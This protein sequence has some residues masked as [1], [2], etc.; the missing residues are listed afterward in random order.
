MPA[1]ATLSRPMRRSGQDPV[2]SSVL[3]RRMGLHGKI[4]AVVTAPMLL[5]ALLAAFIVVQAGRDSSDAR[6][7]ATVNAGLP[8]L[9]RFVAQLQSE[10]TATL[11]YLREQ[12]PQNEGT[13]RKQ[14]Q[15][16]DTSVSRLSQEIDLGPLA[17]RAPA[18]AVDARSL[19]ESGPGTLLV[20]R[21][22][23]D[24][25][26]SSAGPVGA[27][28]DTVMGQAINIPRLVADN[29]ADRDAARSMRGFAS[30]LSLS[31]LAARER[32]L[33][34]GAFDR[35]SLTAPEISTYSKTVTEQNTAAADLLAVTGGDF[36]EL[37]ER[38]AEAVSTVDL[39]PYRI[40][41][42]VALAG[43]GDLS[44]DP[45]AW[46]NDS[47]ERIDAILRL[48]D[49]VSSQVVTLTE[50]RAGNA[51]RVLLSTLTGTVLAALIAVSLT[52]AMSRRITLP[53]RSLTRSA[54]DLS[55]KLPQMVEQMR[56]PGER[57]MIDLE[58]IR[59][60]SR[61]EVGELAS[62]F[63]SVNAVTV[64]VA[65][66]QAALRGSIAAMYTQMARRN[67]VLL[68]R[69]LAYLDELEMKELNSETLSS[70]FRLDHLATRMRRNS[71]SLLVLAGVD[72]SRTFSKPLPLSEVIRGAMGE[73]EDYHRIDLIAGVNA[74][75]SGH[76]AM[77][78]SHLIAELLENATQF[79][80]PQTRV[81]VTLSATETGAAVLIRDQG[82]GMTDRDLT[83]ANERIAAPPVVE[84]AGA[85]QLGF[86]VV[87]RL[88]QRLGAGVALRH[89][90]RGGIVAEVTLPVA[91]LDGAQNKVIDLSNLGQERPT[92]PAVLA[93]PSAPVALPQRRIRGTSRGQRPTSSGR[94]LF[95]TPTAV[96]TT[97]ELG[98]PKPDSAGA[99]VEQPNARQH[100]NGIGQWLRAVTVESGPGRR[101]QHNDDEEHAGGA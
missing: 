53:L 41:V 62:A 26:T 1:E 23:T 42:E 64:R 52:L 92:V 96:T 82:L 4:L 44:R 46:L 48:L 39:T 99:A 68:D 33:L 59:I 78:L 60:E 47:G 9:G 81:Q 98:A 17:D 85:Q 31:E 45:K 87:G 70:L 36:P 55:V 77:S 91:A 50:A 13:V 61:D 56:R 95:E 25:G 75:V 74:Q 15:L 66:E 93:A 11:S 73:I 86:F 22:Q 24:S 5:V 76:L 97:P 100:G 16:T 38:M 71:E 84:V 32:D 3:P 27:L 49:P 72:A 40:N 54:K 51:E 58:P 30:L 89:G 6:D 34:A 43:R 29:L 57:P 79:S 10:R 28:Y 65:E 69:Q 18:A 2:P 83:R 37:G 8:Q 67:Q 7:L 88:A 90:G 101:A 35:G 12:T 94:T 80:H 14:R 63:N 20:A 19:F 21:G